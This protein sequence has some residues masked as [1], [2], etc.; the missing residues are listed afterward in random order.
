M[1]DAF[2]QYVVR[3]NSDTTEGRGGY[4]DRET[5]VLL[6]DAIACVKSGRYGVQGSKGD[7]EV[8]ERKWRIIDGIRWKADDIKIWGYRRDSDGKYGNGFLDLRDSKALENPEY[9]EY[10]RLKEKFDG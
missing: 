8:V 3:G 9:V 1:S 10:L 6:E 4:V 5:F 7:G 2:I